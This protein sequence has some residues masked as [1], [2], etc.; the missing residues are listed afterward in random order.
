MSFTDTLRLRINKWLTN[1]QVEPRLEQVFNEELEL[2]IEE[3]R[4][5]IIMI[6]KDAVKNAVKGFSVDKVIIKPER[7]S[8]LL[9]GHFESAIDTYEDEIQEQ[10]FNQLSDE[11]KQV[12]FFK[13]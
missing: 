10:L 8:E 2:A 4:P 12:K 11:L 3:V 5:E 9:D 6:C 13:G 1:D 7:I